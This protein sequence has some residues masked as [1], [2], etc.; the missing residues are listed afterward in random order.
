M[1]HRTNISKW[2]SF[3]EICVVWKDDFFVAEGI[4]HRA[5]MSLPCH[6][7]VLWPWEGPKTFLLFSVL[8]CMKQNVD[9]HHRIVMIH[10]VWKTSR[11][12]SP[13]S[14]WQYMLVLSCFPAHEELILRSRIFCFL[15]FAYSVLY[16]LCIKSLIVWLAYR[17]ACVSWSVFYGSLS[18]Y[19]M[20]IA[21]VL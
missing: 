2:V 21:K 12:M 5:L 18:R 10:W 1:S 9:N 20:M 3:S 13:H 19:M 15:L 16:L 6:F 17:C 7:L 11:G 4:Q 14:R 8:F